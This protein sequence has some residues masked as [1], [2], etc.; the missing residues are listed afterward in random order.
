MKQRQPWLS[1]PMDLRGIRSSKRVGVSP[2]RQCPAM[3]GRAQ[4]W[5]PLR[6]LQSPLSGRRDHVS[7]RALGNR[8]RLPLAVFGDVGADCG[9]GR[10]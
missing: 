6:P 4:G 8:A 9:S 2:M 3:I 5:H 1:Q 10:R 7:D